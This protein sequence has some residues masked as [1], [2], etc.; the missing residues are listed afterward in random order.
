MLKTRPKY[1]IVFC[2]RIHAL[3]TLR[4]DWVVLDSALPAALSSVIDNVDNTANPLTS[5]S[6]SLST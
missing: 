1:V 2:E 6:E 3:K 5:N 4:R